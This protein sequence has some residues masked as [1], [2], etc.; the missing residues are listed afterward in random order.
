MTAETTGIRGTDEAMS[1]LVAAF[2]KP[3][4]VQ[5]EITQNSFGAKFD[6]II[7]S[8]TLSDGDVLFESFGKSLDGG[9]ISLG[10]LPR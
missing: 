9:S 5:H 7:A 3:S 10:R 6:R 8:W 4:R 2:G 1:S